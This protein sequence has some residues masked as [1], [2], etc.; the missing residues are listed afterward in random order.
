MGMS[1]VCTVLFVARLLHVPYIL[2]HIRGTPQ[3]MQQN[4][5]YQDVV[6]EIT[7]FFSEKVNILKLLGVNDI[8]LDPGFG[9]G[10]TIEHNYQL[11]RRLDEFKL[12]ELPILAGLSRKSM[13]YKYLNTS[14]DEALNG[15]TSLNTIALLQGSNILRVHDVKEAVEAIQLVNKLLE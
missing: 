8:I 5:V 6:Q 3:T 12:F 10:K 4:P 14:P 7:Q 15:T 13:I 11:L 9:F 1:A 2:M